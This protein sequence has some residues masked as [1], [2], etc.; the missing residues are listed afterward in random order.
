MEWRPKAFRAPAAV[1]LLAVLT[2]VAAACSGDGSG[3]AQDPPPGV[4]RLGVEAPGSLD[5]GQARSPSELL[6]AEQLFDGLTS[7][8]AETLGVKPAIAAKWEASPDFKQWDFTLRPDARFGNGRQITSTDVKYT[9]DRIARRGSTSPG[10]T[11]LDL[12]TGFKPYNVTGK[13]GDL[14]GVSTPAPEVVRFTLDAPHALLPAVVGNPVFG[15]VPRES[16]EAVPPSPAFAR[17]PMGSG[18]FVIQSRTD[19]ELRLVPAP[20]RKT[21]IKGID[22]FLA[23]DVA[24]AYAD[25]LRGGVDWAEAPSN[26]FEPVPRG[27][28]EDG[29]RPYIGQL[30]YAFNLKNPKFAD[31]RFRQAIVHAIDRHAIIRVVYGSS[32]LPARGLVAEGVP[33]SQPNPCAEVCRFDPERARALL[34][35]AFGDGRPPEFAIDFDDNPTQAAVAEAM[36]ANLKA[37]GINANLRPHA[38][39]D[40]LK[41]ALSGQ[42]EMFRLGWIGAY[43]HPDAFLTPLFTS[44]TTDNVSG[45]SSGEVDGLLRQARAEPDDGKRL[46]AYQQAEKLVLAQVP[47]LP[48]AQFQTHAVTAPRVENL[49]LTIFG[50]FDASQVRLDD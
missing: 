36:Q 26:Q 31:Q 47:V 18:P 33:G 40:Y 29:F 38:Y 43:P 27:M 9:F 35:E 16:V 28:G 7:Y 10:V 39:G 2:L 14:A 25:F 21:E 3:S 17:Q 11:Q 49:A 1:A 5:P 45:F 37:V 13:A 32:V 41:F 24:S 19:A 6:L 30:F 22:V 50:T 42:Q 34:K 20:D 8:D 12:V 48:V 15:I 44:G 4:L 46:A 23:R